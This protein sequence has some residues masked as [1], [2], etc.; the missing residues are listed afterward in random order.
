MTLRL[1]LLLSVLALAA[2]QLA[3]PGAREY[4]AEIRRTQGGIPHIRANDLA[5]LGFG[6]LYAQAEDNF[7]VL[8]DEILTFAAERSRHLGPQ[9]G[10]LERDLFY[11]L[12]IDRGDAA[13][14]LPEELEALYR[15]AA[16]GYNAYLRDTEPRDSERTDR[17]PSGDRVESRP[18]SRDPRCGS[19]AWLRPA[20]AIDLKRI[21]RIDYA[22]AYLSP[23]LVAAAPPGSDDA[24][25]GARD[26]AARAHSLAVADIAR[27]AEAFLEVPRQGGSNGV[28]IGRKLSRGG[29]GLLLANPHMPWN[30]PF[31]RFYPMHQT[32]PGELDVMGANLLGRPR[33]GFGH[34]ADVAWTSTVSTAKRMSFYR[35]RLKPDDPTQYDFD[36]AWRPMQ[37]RI[38]RVAVRNPTGEVDEVSH[39]FYETHL[40]ALLVESPFFAWSN[41]YAFA[42]RLL[43]AGWRGETSIRDQYRATTVRELKAVHDR[44]QFLPVNLIAADRNGEVLYA[45]PG[46]IPNLP[47]ELVEA[48]SVVAGAALDGSRSDCQWR[49]DAGA[50][51]GGIFAPD[52]LP[53]RFRSDSVTNS[54]DSHWLANPAA[55]LEGFP[56]WI[57]SERTP[58]TIRTRSGLDMLLRLK[59]SAG[60]VD[61]AS[62]RQLALANENHMGRLIRDDVVEFCRATP[63]VELADDREVPLAEACRVLAAWDLHANLDSRGAV[64]FRLLLSSAHGGRFS[65]VYPAGFAPRVAF[66]FADPVA[67]PRGLARASKSVVLEHLARAVVELESAGIA[68]DAPLGA[69]QGVTRNGRRIPLHGGPEIEGIFNKLESDFRGTE[70]YPEVDRWSS[71]WILAVALEAE[72][73]RSFGLLTYSL[74]TDPRSEHFSDQT[75][76]F[77]R[78]QWVP[79]PWTTAEIEAATIRSVS[80]RA[81]RAD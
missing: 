25:A 24:A 56:A 17:A 65:R 16:A 53:A 7:C 78:K 38:V 48:C 71:S 28:A 60:V 29:G 62:L 4:Q 13:Q 12:L 45:D 36:G 51:A 50:A 14:P 19:A 67:T 70:G 32:I 44:D 41:E 75:E 30:E 68:L 21:S 15:G 5:S 55:P 9:D 11:R 73:P 23:M 43:D 42:V 76:R 8:A 64:L 46:P 31:Q 10:N 63:S 57:G 37:K 69:I 3:R 1:G 27:A 39:T 2:C 33:V 77:A 22:L 58:R 74:S 72:G 34:T 59:S 79:L 81:P 47:D 61:L 54:N 18:P 40:G 20:R 49:D 80:L 35:L 52:S 6:T 26:D 66:D